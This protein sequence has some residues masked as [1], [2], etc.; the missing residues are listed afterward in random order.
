MSDPGGASASREDGRVNGRTPDRGRVIGAGLTWLSTWGLRTVLAALGIAVVVWLIGQLW[1]IFLP[2]FL[3]LIVATLLRPPTA[4][5]IRHHFPPALAA[6]TVVVAAF[7]ALGGIVFGLA[8]IVAAQSGQLAAQ[9]TAGVTQ[10]ERW[11][12]GSPLHLNLAGG[13]GSIASRLQQAAPTIASGA[14]TGLTTAASVLL[15]AVLTIVLAFLFVKDAD[16]FLPWMCRLVG[17]P[18]APHLEAVLRRSW[19]ALSN[20]IRIQALVGLLDA[21]LIGLGLFLLGVPLALPLAVL[22]FFGAFVPI[23]GAFITGALAVLIALVAKGLTVALIAL[24]VVLL[25]QQLEGNVFQPILQGHSLRLHPA[26]VLLAVTAGG[27]L[28]GIAGALLAVPVAAVAGE[29]LRYLS[30][31]VDR[32]TR[33]V[34]ADPAPEARAAAEP[35]PPPD[36]L[37]RPG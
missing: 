8:P 5:L 28:F 2:I 23:A 16:R 26:T 21:L 30:E 14:L 20:F 3:G 33:A 32:R 31:Q 13:F 4:W 7:A 17:E 27:T 18:A 29:V 34:R 35:N 36:G 15:T 1:V 10:V 19:R 12:A 11:L 37:L 24:G 6:L 9:V 22:I 25:V